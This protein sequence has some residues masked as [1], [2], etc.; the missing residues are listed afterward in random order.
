MEDSE[1]DRMMAAGR[2]AFAGAAVPE[3]V[4]DRATLEDM[5]AEG[6]IY[7][8]RGL[9]FVALEPTMAELPALQRA[10]EAGAPEDDGAT[11]WQVA[12]ARRL[13]RVRDGET[14]RAA[15]EEELVRCWRPLDLAQVVARTLTRG[16][17]ETSPAGN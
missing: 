11:G 14:V 4:E 9:E 6:T 13:V 1:F 12:L 2:E 3:V 8:R 5:L 10:L 17:M 16:G 15:T 7:R